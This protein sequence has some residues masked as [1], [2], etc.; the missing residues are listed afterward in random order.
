MAQTIDPTPA[1]A[2]PVPLAV[3]EEIEFDPAVLEALC[4]AHGG[5]AEEVIAGALFRVEERLILATWQAE[6]GEAGGLRRTCDELRDL[7]RQIGMTT[8]ERAARAMRDAARRPDDPAFA[9]CAARL[10]RLARP[11]TFTDSRLDGGHSYA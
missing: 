1:P 3:A 6:N 5:F 9:A 2:I 11:G 7:A 4:D 8:L 10:C